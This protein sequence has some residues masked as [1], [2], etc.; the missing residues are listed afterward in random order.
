MRLHAAC[1]IHTFTVFGVL[2]F[3][4]S[5]VS[6]C[7]CSL[8]VLAEPTEPLQLVTAHTSS[9]DFDHVCLHAQPTHEEAHRAFPIF[10]LFTA[11]F[12]NSRGSS[13]PCTA[14]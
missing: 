5:D 13:R 8:R 3:L 4:G 1:D 14:K 12:G 2:T 6:A 9:E 11:L 10:A 7:T